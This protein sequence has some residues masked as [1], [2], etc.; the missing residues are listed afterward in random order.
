M[1][2]ETMSRKLRRLSYYTVPEAGA[3]VHLKRSQSYRAAEAGVIPV[4]RDGKFLLVPRRRWDRK[5]KRL[6][7]SHS[8]RIEA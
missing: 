8:D 4:E 6:L 3:Q 7:S 2:L 1:R 5:V